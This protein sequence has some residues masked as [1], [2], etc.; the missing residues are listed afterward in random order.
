[1]FD[2]ILSSDG[3][4]HT[5]ALVG[6]LD[7]QSAPRV[8]EALDRLHPARATGSCCPWTGWPS[9]TPAV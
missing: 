8:H 1:M 5:L 9:A 2:V 6:E 7:H 4:T 3:G